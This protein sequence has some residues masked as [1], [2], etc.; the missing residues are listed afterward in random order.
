MKFTQNNRFFVSHDD[1]L[2]L[3]NHALQKL[4][5]TDMILLNVDAQERAIAARLAM[6]LR[7]DLLFAENHD[8]FVDVEYNRDG[9]DMKRP[10]PN[11]TGVWIAPDIIIH[12]RKSGAYQGEDKYRNDIVYIEVKKNSKENQADAQKVL[13]QMKQRKYQYGVDLY[14]LSAQEIELNLYE[15]SGTLKTSCQFDFASNILREVNY[16][17]T[18]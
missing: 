11:S 16:G 4:V 14:R 3:F 12:E 9:D 2:Q 17:N 18:H 8:I 13:E 15:C 6:Y 10:A 1:V 7:D 5:I